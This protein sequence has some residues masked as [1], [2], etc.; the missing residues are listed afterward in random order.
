MDCSGQMYCDGDIYYH[1]VLS[2]TTTKMII[3]RGSKLP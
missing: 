2:V 1:N 3:N